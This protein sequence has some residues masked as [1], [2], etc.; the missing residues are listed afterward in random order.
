VTYARVLAGDPIPYADEVE[1]CYG[2]RPERVDPGI[3]EAAHAQLDEL[4]PGEGTLF[5]RRQAWRE[6]QLVSGETVLTVFS[7]LLPL[8]RRRTAELLSLPEGESLTVDAVHDEPWWAFNYYQGDLRSRVVVNVD[9]PTTGL[10]VLHLVAHEVYPGHHTERALKEQLLVREQG[11]VEETIQL[12][13]VPQAL[14]SEGI[15]EVGLEV[16]LDDEVDEE[17]RSILRRKGLVVPEREL[18]ERIR[19]ANDALGTVGLDAALMIHEDGATEA[20]A[21]AFVERWRLV[22]PE[23]AAQNVRFATDPT[24]RAYTITYSAGEELCRAWLAGDPSR[25]RRL[26]TEQVRVGDLTAVVP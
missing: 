17:V 1:Q 16:V 3:Y 12:V 2:V 14:V 9:Q 11:L 15:A 10:D 26:L 24:W 7:E 25:L 18:A 5:E 22:P 6:S 13:P 19:Q 23:Q 21:E 4:L 20:E 8:L